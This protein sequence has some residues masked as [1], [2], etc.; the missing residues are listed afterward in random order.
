LKSV[1]GKKKRSNQYIASLHRRIASPYML[2]WNPS[3][4]TKFELMTFFSYCQNSS[5]TYTV[6]RC[7]NYLSKK[8]NVQLTLS[9]LGT[10]KSSRNPGAYIVHYSLRLPQGT[11]QQALNKP[12]TLKIGLIAMPQGPLKFGVAMYTVDWGVPCIMHIH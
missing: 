9:I 4:L 8:L 5:K 1:F 6:S 3:E 12:C 10:Y 7:T 2:N 11:F